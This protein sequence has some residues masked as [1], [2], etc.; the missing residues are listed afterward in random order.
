MNN[1]INVDISQSVTMCITMAVLFLLM[2]LF[3]AI[4]KENAEIFISGFNGLSKKERENYDRLKIS[5]HYRN[6][7][8]AWAG[9][10]LVSAVLCFF[11]LPQIVWIAYIIWII[12]LSQNTHIDARKAFEKYKL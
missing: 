9:I 6:L 8:L 10:F 3:F 1:F 2:A 4:K 11:V 7:F 12:S 5:I